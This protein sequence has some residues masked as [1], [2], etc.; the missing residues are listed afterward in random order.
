MEWHRILF[1]DH[2]NK[3]FLEILL[4][5]PI[6]FLAVFAVLRISGKRGGQ[7]LS[8]L[9]I[10]MI[11][12]LGSAAG[13]A[14]FYEEVGIL[15]ALAV[16]VIVILLYRLII[17]IIT[18]SD[19]AEEIIEGNPVYI[20]RKGILCLDEMKGDEL[21]T[22]EL[23]AEL[24]VFN[25]SHLGQLECAILEA[26]GKISL[27]YYPDEKVHVGLPILPDDYHNKVSTIKDPGI[28]ACTKCGRTSKIAA[29]ESKSCKCGG[30]EWLAAKRSRRIT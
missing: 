20:I 28:Y 16:F 25:V 4:R 22:D 21:G 26:N 30:N 14:M 10:V 11:I 24:R 13:D 9:E 5:T 1:S 6:M 27:F 19:K 12:T 23:F 7:Q 3:F 17:Y 2:E 8:I 18:L 15:H 29:D